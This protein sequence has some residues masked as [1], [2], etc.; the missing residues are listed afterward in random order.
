MLRVRSLLRPLVV[1]TLAWL[2]VPG[3]SEATENLWHL[4][5]TGHGAH[6]LS[7]GAGHAPQDEEHGCTGTFHLCSC[8]HTVPSEL[9]PAVDLRRCGAVRESLKQTERAVRD[10]TPSPLEHPPQLERR[11]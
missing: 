2:L 7:A 8:H 3:L 9:A 6:D 10:G 1:A 4:L 11:A 5:R